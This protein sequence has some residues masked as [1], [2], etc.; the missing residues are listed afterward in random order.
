VPSIEIFAEADLPERYAWQA[1]ACM[2]EVWPSLFTGP[3]EWLSRPA[4]T[5]LS[6]YHFV[7]H[8]DGAF[9]SYASVVRLTVAH[10]GEEF[11]L[12][13]L[14]NVLTPTPYRR[15]GYAR[16]VLG[17]VNDWLDAGGADAAA[18]FCAQSLEPF[19]AGHGWTP[20]PGG[21]RL[22]DRTD[23][24]PYDELRMM[25]F[26]SGRARA[27]REALTNETLYVTHLW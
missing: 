4:D 20:C 21:T 3:L 26:L 6:P 14:G 25:R 5:D 15:R 23:S 18:L 17:E 22:G 13:G 7:L 19:Y 24:R 10:G 27:A 8:R 11:G 1:V 2:R 9:A 12:H 16:R